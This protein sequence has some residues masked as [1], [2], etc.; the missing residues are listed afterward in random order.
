[1]SR[2]FPLW[3]HVTLLILHEVQRFPISYTVRPC[4]SSQNYPFCLWKNQQTRELTGAR[5]TSHEHNNKR[6]ESPSLTPVWH[7]SKYKVRKLQQR[8]VLNRHS[9]G[10]VWESRW[11]SWAVRPNEPSGFR[12][13]KELLNRASALV[14]TCP[15]YVNWHLRTLSITSTSSSA[16]SMPLIG[17]NCTYSTTDFDQTELH[18]AVSNGPALAHGDDLWIYINKF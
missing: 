2:L 5:K 12:G 4:D 9:S 6:S 11:P 16:S 15:L 8:H 1:M 17:L 3:T 14:T 7:A 18:C 13:C 10:A